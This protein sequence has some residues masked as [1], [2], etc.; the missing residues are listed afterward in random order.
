MIRIIKYVFGAIAF[1]AMMSGCMK[2]IVNPSKN[3]TTSA[4]R[5]YR[6]GMSTVVNNMTQTLDGG[7]VVCGDVALDT[8]GKHY[9]FLMKTDSKGNQLWQKEYALTSQLL[10]V[11]Q[12]SDGGYIAVGTASSTVNSSTTGTFYNQAYLLKTDAN[13]NTQWQN[14]FG[15]TSDCGFWDVSETPDHG[16]VAAGQGNFASTVYKGSFNLQMYAVKTDQNGKMLWQNTYQTSRFVG[17]FSNICNLPG[18]II[19]LS[20]IVDQAAVAGQTG[21]YYPTNVLIDQKGEPACLAGIYQHGISQFCYRKYFAQFKRYFI[22]FWC[23][24]N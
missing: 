7:Y 14:T 18:N 1:L 4:I 5:L 22:R 13:G 19:C 2:T 16:F 3:I 11:R 6:I 17:A 21:Y 8:S 9:A 12:T 20:G 23:I 10:N 15:D 24:R